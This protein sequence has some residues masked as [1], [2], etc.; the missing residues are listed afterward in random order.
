GGGGGGGC[1]GGFWGGFGGGAGG[2]SACG[3]AGAWGPGAAGT[4][5]ADAPGSPGGGGGSSVTNPF[6]ASVTSIR[7]SAFSPAATRAES[8]SRLRITPRTRSTSGDPVSRY[9]R[10]R[11]GRGPLLHLRPRGAP[12]SF[13]NCDSFQYC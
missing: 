2:G 10:S 5:V 12:F 1:G 3:A 7:S 8:I 6:R 13:S 11:H 9:A 4:P